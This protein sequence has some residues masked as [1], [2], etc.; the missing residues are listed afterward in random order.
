MSNYI[1]LWILDEDG[2]PREPKN[3]NDE[4]LLSIFVVCKQRFDE[5]Q[6]EMNVRHEALE[7]KAGMRLHR[8]KHL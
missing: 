2:K 7:K 3:L 1:K 5:I 6:E 4:Q 8:F